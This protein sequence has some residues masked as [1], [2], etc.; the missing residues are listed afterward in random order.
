MKLYKFI[1]LIIALMTLAGVA[2]Y[3]IF[4]GDMVSEAEPE[5]NEN[6]VNVIRETVL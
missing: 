4:T 5:I 2:V 3:I 1:V 6:T